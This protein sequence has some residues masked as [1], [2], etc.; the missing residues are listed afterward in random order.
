MSTIEYDFTDSY[1]VHVLVFISP[2]LHLPTPAPKGDYRQYSHPQQTPTP[3]T[4][5]SHPPHL[6]H[7]SP[8]HTLP[9]RALTFILSLT[10]DAWREE[11]GGA[12]WWL[13]SEP[14]SFIPRFNSLIL[15]IPSIRTFHMVTPVIGG[16]TC[17]T[18][19][20]YYTPF[21]I[22]LFNTLSFYHIYLCTPII[23]VYKPYVTL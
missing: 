11:W 20:L 22:H 5:P 15:F 4:T 21:I 12:L 8:L 16:G 1:S 9:G 19:V 6:T 18:I 14:T 23:H 7:P 13:N 2:S 10:D 17:T 3:T